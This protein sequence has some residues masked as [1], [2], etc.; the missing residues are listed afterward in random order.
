MG[1]DLGELTPRHASS[2]EE[3][4]GKRLAVDA[5]NTL[6]QFLTIIRSPDGTPLM[7]TKGRITSHL[8]GLLYRTSS[9]VELGVQPVF[10]FDGKPPRLKHAELDTRSERKV[11]AQKAYQAA[12]EAGDTQQAY[13]KAKQAARLTRDMVEQA[14]RLLDLLGVANFT[15]PSE[16]EAQASHMATKGDVWAVC[17]QDYDCL[18]FGAPRLVRNVTITG[19]RKMPGAKATIDVV[20]ER[21]ETGE[22]YASLGL[23]REQLIDVALL[24]GTD[25]NAGIHGLGPR[26]ALALVQQHGSLE[27]IYDAVK[28]ETIKRDSALYR[29]LVEG[30]QGLGPYE[31]IRKLF[32]EP[33]V[34]DSY[35]LEPR[36]MDEQAV[37]AMLVDDHQ[38]SRDRVLGALEKFRASPQTKKQRSLDQFFG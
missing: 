11:V 16:G 21:V 36:A 33:E 2:L 25:F 29:Y 32:L 30:R 4:A 19:K 3:I 8:A 20:P 10:V 34:T 14:K 24:V 13:V 5:Y 9:L 27:G 15:A 17:S 12:R 6:Y 28:A 38:F 7:D 31:E 37:L 35:R 26:K 1:V 22:V 23:R 18:L